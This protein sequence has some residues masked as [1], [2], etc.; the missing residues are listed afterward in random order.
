[1]SAPDRPVILCV[2]DST[3]LLALM[4][5]ALRDEYQV[6]TAD[7]PGDAIE[8]AFG[9]PRPDLILLDV[10]M[11]DVSGFE[12]CQA[13]KG[14]TATA[15]IP[16]IFLTSRTGAQDQVDG[17]QLGAV[18]YVGKPIN[19][20]VLKSRV[21]LHVALASQ[22]RQLFQQRDELASRREELERMVP[23]DVP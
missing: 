10:D 2:D 22:H 18:D 23:D 9:D 19:A 16:I 21:R 3:D 8:K 5:K 7:N 6:L 1:M 13:L 12:V 17:L 11:P 4:E 20:A 14:E 15:D